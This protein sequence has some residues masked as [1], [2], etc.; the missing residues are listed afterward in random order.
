MIGSAFAGARM[1][2]LRFLSS[3]E[4]TSSLISPM[5][6]DSVV[7]SRVS[8]AGLSIQPRRPSH[9]DLPSSTCI[10]TGDLESELTVWNRLVPGHCP[11]IAGPAEG[12]TA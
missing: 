12:A 6:C 7:T 5:P 1:R 8:A 11:D 4:P 10:A 9:A 3:L 2:L